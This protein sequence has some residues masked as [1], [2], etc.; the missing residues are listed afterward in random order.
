MNAV[1][2]G[3]MLGKQS[4]PESVNTVHDKEWVKKDR[5]PRTWELQRAG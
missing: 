4:Y 5:K 1:E 2:D 3:S